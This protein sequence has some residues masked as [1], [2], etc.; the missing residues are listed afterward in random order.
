M[1][2]QNGM[3]VIGVT[4]YGTSVTGTVASYEYANGKVTKLFAVTT[5]GSWYRLKEWKLI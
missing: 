1:K 2:V 5:E 4:F 3:S